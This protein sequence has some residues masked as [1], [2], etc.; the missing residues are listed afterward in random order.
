MFISFYFAVTWRIK[1]YIYTTV[2]FVRT[3]IDSNTIVQVRKLTYDCWVRL[4]YGLHIVRV[5]GST[6]STR[7]GDKLRSITH[8]KYAGELQRSWGHGCGGAK[9]IEFNNVGTCVLLWTSTTCRKWRRGDKGPTESQLKKLVVV[10]LYTDVT[11]LNDMKLVHWPWA[12]KFGT[13]R[14]G[15]GGATASPGYCSL[16]QM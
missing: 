4:T 10:T 8:V 9:L 7:D 16:Y 5:S 6:D 3:S 11:T 2:M 13:A 12:V 14:R 1:M 15:L